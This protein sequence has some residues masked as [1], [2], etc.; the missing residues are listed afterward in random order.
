MKALEKD[1]TRRYE[2]AN[3][4]AADILRHLA[5]EPVL[6]APPSRIYRMRK[7]VR[8]NRGAVI[9]AS[10]VLLALLAGFIGT[11]WGLIQ[12]ERANAALKVKNVEL[13]AEKIKV[14]KRFELAH[15]AIGTF[16]TGVSEDVLLK[17]EQ[18]KDLRTRL[19]REAAGF[20]GNLETLL[21]GQTDTK[22]RKLLAAGYHQLGDL[23]DKI[24]ESTK[25]L[26]VLRKALEVRRALA[27]ESPSDL[28]PRLDVARTLGAACRLLDTTGDTPAE[29]QA[30]EELRAM[31]TALEAE[32]PTDDVLEVLAESYSTVAVALDNIGKIPPS[33]EAWRKAADIRRRLAE[34]HPTDSKYQF[35]LAKSYS[36]LGIQVMMSWPEMEEGLTFQVNGVRILEKLIREH[37]TSTDYQ[38]WLAKSVR[39]VG[40]AQGV[41]LWKPKEAETEFIASFPLWRKLAETYPAVNVYQA[42]LGQAYAWFGWF[43]T[44]SGRWPQALD[45]LRKSLAIFQRLIESEAD[46]PWNRLNLAL[47][48]QYAGEVLQDMGEESEAMEALRRS[49]VMGEKAVEGDPA[50]AHHRMYLARHHEAVGTLLERVGKPAEA[51]KT[52]SEAYALRR[53]N[54]EALPEDAW[55]QRDLAENRSL[56]G[57][58]CRDTGKL[59]EALD[60]VQTSLPIRRKLVAGDPTNP[61]YQSF[62]SSDLILAASILLRLGRTAEAR[63]SI[64]E[65]IPIQTG[66][67][68]RTP[69]YSQ[70]AAV[71]AHGYLRSGQVRQARGDKAGAVA[72]W[73]RAIDVLKTIP[74]LRGPETF[75]LACCHAALS[76]AASQPEAAAAQAEKAMSLLNKATGMSFRSPD[77][78]RSETALEPVRNRDDFKKLMTDLEERATKPLASPQ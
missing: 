43:Q 31:A 45:N 28:E 41:M 69:G 13:A 44:Y 59:P 36:D 24:G 75:Q 22:S 60:A 20:Y 53:R 48:S 78:F 1:R 63:A 51:L 30:S 55:A 23:T 18:F 32:S 68:K 2:T 7:F 19:L 29:L 34:A 77:T 27:A 3:G 56:V 72:D 21:E 67:V 47:T 38:F 52:Y 16:H 8:K 71:L 49:V 58:L 70:H 5:S 10:L 37:P 35:E 42:E 11:T 73:T 74:S 46:L 50:S 4:F 33:R 76:G 62:L 64:E 14:E 25:A 12:A 6:A 15:K 65:A 26:A 61:K 9:A 54:A 39:D 66:A 17:N 57:R 40:W